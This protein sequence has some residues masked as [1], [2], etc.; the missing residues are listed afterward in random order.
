MTVA[1]PKGKPWSVAKIRSDCFRLRHRESEIC[2]RS[3]G[4]SAPGQKDLMPKAG[5]TV[6]SFTI[7]HQPV[8]GGA[9]AFLATRQ[10][11]RLVRSTLSGGGSHSENQFAPVHRRPSSALF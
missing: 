8:R 9:S 2:L 4:I 6:R 3:P 5:L 7:L 11:L 1:I 10:V